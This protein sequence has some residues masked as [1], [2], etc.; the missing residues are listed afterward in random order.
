MIAARSHGAGSIGFQWRRQCT[1]L[2]VNGS[3]SLAGAFGEGAE[4]TYTL[5]AEI[6][7]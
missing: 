5:N 3:V 6:A 7:N 2:M 1:R 4:A